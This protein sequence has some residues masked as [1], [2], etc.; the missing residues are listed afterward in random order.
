MKWIGTGLSDIGRVRHINQDAYAVDNEHQLW[1]VADGMGG[2]V[3][4]EIASRL[5]VD[6]L[7]QTVKS[8][9][10]EWDRVPSTHEGARLLVEA[11]E[12]ANQAVRAYAIE[13]PAYYGMGT[14]IAVLKMFDQLPGEA[15]IAHAGDSRIYRVRD[16][17][18]KTL[19]RD[20]SL[21]QDQIDLGLLRPEEAEHHPLRHI[22]TKA[23]G[24]EPRVQPAVQPIDVQPTD[25]FLLCTD[26]LTKMLGDL[27]IA[28]IIETTDAKGEALCRALIN[29][30]NARGGEDNVTIVVIEPLDHKE[31]I[32]ASTSEGRGGTRPGVQNSP[33]HP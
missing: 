28:K 3:G 20:H 4:G 17:D 7:L 15:V 5:A 1:I 25:R 33:P 9:A 24:I 13:H 10:R 18:L 22:L 27:D 19:T 11:V 12:M 30:A 14:T 21:V 32:E 8:R 26:G 23:L 2:H 29:E 31:L 16:R 6:S